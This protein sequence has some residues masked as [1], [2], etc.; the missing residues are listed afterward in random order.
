MKKVFKYLWDRKTAERI[1]EKIIIK[2]NPSKLMED[3]NLC[4]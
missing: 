1:F 2:N 3:I 4:L